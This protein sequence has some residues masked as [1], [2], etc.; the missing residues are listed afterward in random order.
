MRDF[1]LRLSEEFS[2]DSCSFQE[3][4][5]MSLSS[6]PLPVPSPAH[7]RFNAGPYPSDDSMPSSPASTAASPQISSR[8]DVPQAVEQSL[9]SVAFNQD[10]GCFSCGTQT[11]FRIYNCDPFKETFR[12][13]FDGAGIA[14]VEML[15][16][17]ASI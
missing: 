5:V 6:P 16:R 10:H 12:R 1:D 7:D 3:S 2:T 15:F 4:D 13:E 11:G 17:Y 9:L 14:I 8:L